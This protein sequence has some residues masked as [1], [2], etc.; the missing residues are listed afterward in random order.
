MTDQSAPALRE[1]R[2]RLLNDLA[3][4]DRGLHQLG[5]PVA[6][7]FTLDCAGH[8]IRIELPAAARVDA[9][10]RGEAACVLERCAQELRRECVRVVG[11]DAA[12]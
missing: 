6:D 2:E 4:V 8:P 1:E 7:T 9:V 3:T 11:E 5:T 10:V 12:E